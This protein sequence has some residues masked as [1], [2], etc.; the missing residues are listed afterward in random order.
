MMMNKIYFKNLPYIGNLYLQSIYLFFEEPILFLC[1]DEKA[2][3]FLCLCS[4]FREE[5]RWIVV[6]TNNSILK[7]MIMNEIPAY[8]VFEKSQGKK[9]LITWNGNNGE[10]ENITYLNFNEIPDL[11]LPEKDALLDIP[12]SH[13][14]KLIQELYSCTIYFASNKKLSLHIN[15]KSIHSQIRFNL[16]KDF[17]ITRAHISE[18]FIQKGGVTNE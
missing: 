17:N 5:Y 13:Q 11:D 9:Y 18:W 3:K 15:N 4:E 6:E 16:S 2:N 14:I 12:Q 1:T 7:K 8:E 10:N